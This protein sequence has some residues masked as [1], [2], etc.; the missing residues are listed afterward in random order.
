MNRHFWTLSRLVVIGLAVGVCGCASREA[1]RPSP[2]ERVDQEPADREEPMKTP[3]VAPDPEPQPP[4]TE[5]VPAETKNS[6]DAA[7]MPEPSA[8]S[9]TLPATE[10]RKPLPQLREELLASTNPDATLQ[11]IDLIGRRRGRARE[12]LPDLVGLTTANDPRVR[13]HAARSIGLIGEDAI[14]E[15]PAHQEFLTWVRPWAV[16]Q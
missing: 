13:W 8:E 3:P 9:G 5:T 6:A 1:D 11:L 10:A 16:A 7:S 2:V 15:I 12:A 4:A 14:A